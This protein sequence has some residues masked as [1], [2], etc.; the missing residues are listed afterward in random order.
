MEEMHAEVSD[1][2]EPIKYQGS[3]CIILTVQ[4]LSD[5]F[6]QSDS[7]ML[8]YSKCTHYIPPA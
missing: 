5:A 8:D 7:E 2:M 6:I 3:Y 4:H 1:E